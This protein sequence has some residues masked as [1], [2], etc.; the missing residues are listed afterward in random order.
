MLVYYLLNTI[1]II[2]IR[3]KYISPVPKVFQHV[4]LNFIVAVGQSLSHVQILL[5]PWMASRWVFLSF[6]ISWNLL[7]LMSIESVMPS[8]HLTLCC[9]LLLPS[10]F[11]SITVFSNEFVLPIKWP[12]DW[13]FNFSIS[14]FNEYIGFIS[15]RFDWFDPLAVQG[16][17][18]SLFRYHSLKASILQLSLLYS[19]TLTSVHDY[20]KNHSLDYMDLCQQSDVSA[21]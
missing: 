1:L 12:K 17:L 19:T 8:N 16:I 21:F 10:I 5:I 3:S 15:Y 20:C 14:P 2:W 9:T 13:S 4:A 11:L 18:R 7:K 6:I